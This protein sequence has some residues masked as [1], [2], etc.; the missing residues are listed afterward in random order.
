MFLNSSCWLATSD[1]T[2]EIG[3]LGLQMTRDNINI[4]IINYQLHK[5]YGDLFAHYLQM[6]RDNINIAIFVGLA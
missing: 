2:Q 3:G 6:T 1:I 4:V 5:G